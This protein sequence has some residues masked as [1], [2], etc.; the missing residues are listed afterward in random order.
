M[1]TITGTN[2]SDTIVDTSGSSII[3]SGAGADN[4]S[5]GDGSDLVN[6]GS[7][8]D[9]VDGG[10]GSDTLRGDSGNDT[11]IYVAAENVGAVDYYDGGSGY[12]TIKLVL[13][14]AEWFNP[15]FQSD[16]ASYLA[17]MNGTIN[18]TNQAIGDSEFKFTAFNLTV[19]RFEN[20]KIVVDGVELSAADD[21]VTANDDSASVSEDGP[22]L[23]GNVLTNDSVPDLVASVVVVTPPAIGTLAMN[24]GGVKGAYTYDPGAAFN[25]LAAGETASVTFTYKVTDA[26]GDFDEATVT[27]TITGTNDDPTISAAV[28]TGDVTE[29]A[30]DPT[31]TDTGTI[32]FDDVDLTDTHTVS[33]T[34]DAGNTLGGTLTPVVTDPATGAGDGTVTWTY[35]VLNSAVQYLAAGET[36]TEIFTVTIDDGQ[37]GTVDQVVTITVTGT[38]D[39]P[40]LT[41]DTSGSV[42]E[43]VAVSGGNLTDSGTLSF[44]DVDVTDTHTVS[45]VYNGDAVWSGGSLSAAQVTAITSGFAVDSDSWDYT[46]ANADLQFLGAGETITLS[47]DVTVTDDSGAGNDSDTET[48]TVTITGTNDAPAISVDGAATFTTGGPAVSVDNTVTIS[49]VDNTTLS[50]AT[51]TISGGFSSGDSLNF[52]NQLGITGT[53]NAITGVLT[54]A[55]VASLADY[56]TAIESITFSTTSGSTTSRTISYTVNDGTANSATDTATVSIVIGADPNDNNNDSQVLA[57]AQSGTSAPETLKGTSNADNI[58]GNQGNDIMYGGAGADTLNGNADNDLIYGGSGNDNIDGGGGLD[59]I[60]GG[61]GADSITGQNEADTI[62][63]GSDNDTINGGGGNAQDVLIGGYGADSLTGGN[64]SDTF[65]Y[66]SLNDGGDSI[67]DF[68]TTAPG[69]GGDILDISAVLDVAGNTWSDGGTFNDAVTGGYLTFTSNGGFVQVNV[70]VDGSAGSTFAATGMATL[71]S[72]SFATF[73]ASTLSDN[74]TLD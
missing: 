65:R 32:T 3:N 50:G 59:T 52:I 27:I 37:G 42:Q 72:I 10:S 62:Y 19:K 23:S 4:V 31:L 25:Y 12:D 56:E 28:D 67:T 6:A 13:T 22:A 8:D 17:F 70:D 29:D 40:V 64:S 24:V 66:L 71:T 16:L 15:T 5:A 74:V 47:F 58:S 7:G 35:E 73:T 48:V 54:L 14:S 46:V 55:G 53:Y 51:I 44:T 34:P 18:P 26:D 61:S 68:N 33:A 69:S 20:L 21:P 60:F 1:S 63:G 38:N 57:T 30:S 9:V 2:G 45:Q 43:D 11:L 39:A 41:V 49:D 36:A